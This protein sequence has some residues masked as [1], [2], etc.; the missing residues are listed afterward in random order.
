MKMEIINKR[1][2]K[3]EKGLYK[4]IRKS[5]DYGSSISDLQKK[6]F[7]SGLKNERGRR[8]DKEASIGDRNAFG[9]KRGRV[10]EYVSLLD[11][12]KIPFCRRRKPY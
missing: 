8:N 1:E 12:C 5:K 2:N 11:F 4:C 3:P 7:E 6:D 10:I 9:I